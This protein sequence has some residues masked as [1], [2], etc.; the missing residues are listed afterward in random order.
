M[1]VEKAIETTAVV[2]AESQ[3]EV[4]RAQDFLPLLT[5]DQAIARKGQIN[6]FIKGVMVEGE[7]YGTIPGGQQKKVLLKPGAEKLCSIFGMSVTYHAGTVIEDWTGENHGGEPL[8]SYEYRC[9]LSRG[10]RFMGEAV[11]SCNSWESK[12]RYRWVSEDIAKQRPDF[13]KLLKRGGTKTIFEPIFALDKAET[14]GKYG[15]PK[16]Y[17]D[18]FRAAAE[19]GTAVHTTKKLGTRT[20]DGWQMTVDETQYRIPNP[21]IADVINTC[22]KMAQKRALVSAVLVVTNCSDAFTQDL[23]DEVAPPPHDEPPPVDEKTS[24]QA[25]EGGRTGPVS[26]PPPPAGSAPVQQALIDDRPIPEELQIMIAGLKRNPK[27]LKPSYDLLW[28][29]CQRRG[30]EAMLKFEERNRNFR[31]R[32]PRGKPQQLGDHISHILD[33]WQIMEKFPERETVTDGTRD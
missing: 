18:R 9:Q 29:N 21:D 20:F 6:Q 33:L 32:F 22:Q 10:P 31:E 3:H 27:E 7:D 8:F 16:E 25:A 15:K 24:P 19:D 5:L 4:V 23:D 30:P 14:T 12:Y 26:I 1:S 2:V 28:D 11:G 17:W 13:E